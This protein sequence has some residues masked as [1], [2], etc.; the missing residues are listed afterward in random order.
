[1]GLER[2]TDKDLLEII[3]SDIEQELL[4]RGYKYGWYKEELF[5]G[6]IYILVNPAFPNLVKIGYADDLDKRLKQ[7]NRN[8]GLPDPFHVYA[9][10][11]VK[12]RLEDL[13]LHSLIDSLDKT[14]RHSKNREFYEMTAEKA[15]GILVAIAQINGSEENLIL[16]PQNDEYINQKYLTTNPIKSNDTTTTQQ[17]S[18]NIL[19]DGVYT[20][21]RKNKRTGCSIDAKIVVENGTVT[22][23]AG[24]Y[25]NPYEQGGITEL[26]RLIRE[27][28]NTTNDNILQEDLK[29]TLN[30]SS[31]VVLGG[32][33]NA[34]TTWKNSDGEYI[35]VYRK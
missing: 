3:D 16:N 19:P 5:V 6:V 12:K 33:C 1:M 21:S 29:C 35:D 30:E 8:S 22:L 24:S 17:S 28:L 13:K 14:L 7:L 23:K 34:W 9:S 20:M 26:I 31:M 4:S 11:S 32:S 25:I 15:Y 2:Y 18:K 10:Y 27:K